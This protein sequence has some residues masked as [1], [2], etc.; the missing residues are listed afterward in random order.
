MRR[1]ALVALIAA[2]CG[3]EQG[4]SS[5]PDGGGTWA[6]ADLDRCFSSNECPIGWTCNESG[7]CEPPPVTGPDAAPPA[8]VEREFSALSSA[9]RYVYVTMTDLDALAKIDGATLAV[10]SVPVG[11]QPEIVAAVPGTDDAVVLDRGSATATIVRPTVDRDEKVTLRTLPRMNVLSMPPAPS[12]YA[13]A[14]FD[15]TAAV[16]EAGSVAEVGEIGSFQDVT[17]MALSRGEEVA[18]DLSVGFRPRE[19]EFDAAGARA[20]VV[21][22]DGVSVID[23]AEAAAGGAHVAAAIPVAAD[24]L[25]DPAFIEVDVTASGEWAVVRETGRAEL[26]VVRMLGPSAGEAWTLPLPAEATDV[27]LT[28]DGAR[29]Y[30][31]LR[32]SSQLA[33]IDMPGDAMDPAGMELVD[34]GGEIVGSAAISADGTHAI[35]YTNASDEERVTVVDLAGAGYPHVV[36]PL[37]KGVRALAF[38]PDG[39]T[40]LILHNKRPGDPGTATSVDELVDRSYGYSL[41]DLDSGFA[42]LALTPV[43]PGAFAF[44]LDSSHAYLCLDGGDSEGAVARLEVLDLQTFVVESIELGSPPEAVGVLPSAGV[45]YVSQRH[46]LGRVTFVDLESAATRTVTGFELNSHIV[47]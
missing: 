30:A 1:F 11:D 10:T 9:L 36:R 17:V 46:G 16:A 37:Q 2:S 19:V 6:D 40:A 28:A 12:R 7:S 15:L 38:A 33:V 24:P 4:L 5:F 21:T 29:A 32:S 44:A 14:W 3:A 13:V 20:F 42:K 22:D 39:A 8:E 43:D 25:S 31:V 35:L 26:R 45:V 47:D 18:V 41:L 34:V 23:L 27:D